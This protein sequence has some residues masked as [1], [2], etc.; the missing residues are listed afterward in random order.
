MVIQCKGINYE[1]MS[2]V[3]QM[4][5]EEGFITFLNTLKFPVQLYVQTRS[6]N[7]NENIERYKER[8]KMFQETEREVSKRYSELEDDIDAEVDDIVLAK[9]EKIKYTNLLEY[10]EDITNY[11]ETL[12]MN[13]QML[14]RKFYVILSYNKS[15][16]ITTEKFSKSEYEDLCYR[17]LYTRAQGV[18]G[19]LMSCSVSSHILTS[20]ELAELLYISLNKDDEKTLDIRKAIESGFYRLYTTSDDVREKKQQLIEEEIMKESMKRI[21]DSIKEAIRV[22]IIVPE[23][24][25]IDALDK[26]I[27]KTALRTI[28]SSRV[29]DEIKEELKSN[30]TEKRRERMKAKAEV[31]AKKQKELEDVESKKAEEESNITDELPSENVKQDEKNDT[32]DSN[33]QNEINDSNEIQNTEDQNNNNSSESNSD[34]IIS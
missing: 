8:V 13:K 23:E 6:I 3:E 10:V 9:Q 33:S 21:E 17:E 31:E 34:E 14:Q 24:D 2:D 18:V 4:A 30:I 19:S 22:G 12:A 27:D 28:E 25:V 20:N 15:D 32:L 16:L 29:S 1:L 5:V 11:V 26:E 7:L